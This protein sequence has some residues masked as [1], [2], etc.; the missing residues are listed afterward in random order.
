MTRH[1]FVARHFS[2][3]ARLARAGRSRSPT[4]TPSS[5]RRSTPG[6]STRPAC[7]VMPPPNPM[8]GPFFVE[9]AE[10]GDA[11]AVRIDRMTANRD[12][13]WT[14]GPVAP[15]VVDPAA[16]ALLPKRERVLWR[17]DARGDVARLRSIRR[18][19]SPI[20]RSPFAPMLGCFGVAPPLGQ[21]ISTAT[22]GPYGGNMDYRRFGPGTTA[23]FPVFAPRR[24]VLPRRRA[25][26]RKAT[27]RS[28]ARASKP[29]SRSSSPSRC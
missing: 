16:A 26:L 1:R 18:R 8:T 2:Q 20:S 28:S 7:A 29:R 6:A 19:R 3:H 4:A 27:A 21:A 22:S 5:P 17:L 10:P 14:F 15:N 23:Y 12:E 13:G 9:G 25:F 24:A 11:L